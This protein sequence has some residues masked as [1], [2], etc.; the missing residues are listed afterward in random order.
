MN[1]RN[2]VLLATKSIED[3][4][5]ETIDL[6]LKDVISRITVSVSGT[7]A[8]YVP[9]GHPASIVTSIQ[10]VDGS[11]VIFSMNGRQAQALSFYNNHHMDI[12]ALNY[13]GGASAKA[14]ITLNFGRYLY[15]EMF[16]LDPG[17]YRNLQLKVAHDKALGGCTPTAGSIRVFADLFDEKVITPVGYL[18]GREIFSYTPVPGAAEYVTLPTDETIRMLLPMNI[19]YVQEPNIQF[20]TVKLDEDDGKHIIFDGPCTDLLRMEGNIYD[21]ISESLSGRVITDTTPFYISACKDIQVTIV[22]MAL[23]D[24]NVWHPWAG[25]A[26]AVFDSS[27]DTLVRG[28]ATGRCPHGAVPILFGK[29]NDPDDWWDVSRVGK[30]R[31]ILTPK[32]GTVNEDGCSNATTNDVIVQSAVKY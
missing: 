20:K 19:S 2:A 8:T 3:S 27:A 18:K 22:H 24:T 21:R 10:I 32:D 23:V 26:I 30:A 16:A 13:E 29:Q 11:E 4:G 5:T 31:L 17:K 1:Y 7:N 14:S 25:G 9:A 6:D 12:N 28:I 15:D